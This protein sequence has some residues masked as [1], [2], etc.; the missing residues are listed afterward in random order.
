MNLLVCIKQVPDT[1][2]VKFDSETNNLI[3]EGVPSIINPYDREALELALRMREENGGEVIA[4]SMGPSQ[5]MEALQECLDMGADKAVLLSDRK[6]AGSDTLA[7]GYILSEAI[8][9]FDYDYI[10]CGSEAIDGCTGQVGPSIATNLSIPQFTYVS[11]VKYDNGTLKVVRNIG[12]YAVMCET[13]QKAVICVLRGIVSPRLPKACD[14]RP[15]TMSAKDLPNLDPNRIGSMGS[16]T[17]VVEL[18][19]SNSSTQFYVTID[20][21]LSVKERIN[22]IVSGGITKKKK[23]DLVRGSAD[24]LAQKVLDLPQVC[25][26]V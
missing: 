10:L 1:A 25:K 23:V 24:T 26:Y 11:S 20:D 22:M 13:D 2:N 6:F 12:K 15:T 19:M 9:L 21:S 7:T 17:R 4:I 14:K 3:R 5:A 16:P 18:E 8:R